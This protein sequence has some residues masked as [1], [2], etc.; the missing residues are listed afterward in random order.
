VDGGPHVSE[1]E[2]PRDPGALSDAGAPSDPG[3]PRDPGALR[4]LEA[5]S[6]PGAQADGERVARA[7]LT[8][9]AEPG[10]PWLAAVVRRHG[11]P[12]TVAA[13]REGRYPAGGRVT[14]GAARAMERWR[15]RLAEIPQ[16]ADLTRLASLGYRLVCPADPLWPAGLKD[17]ADGEPYGLWVRGAVTDLATVTRRSVA[18]VGSRAATAYGSYVAAEI[19]AS[20][21]AR[22]WTVIS[23]GAYGI[24]GCAHRGTI[25]AGGVTM[26]ILACGVDRPY[27]AGHKDLL[28]AVA[29]SGAVISE[30]PPGRSTARLRFLVRN[31]VIAA[32][33]S[34]TLV[35]EAGRRS[36]ALNTARHAG[37]LSRPLM[38]VPGPVTSDL[39]A[40]CHSIIRDWG[41][42]LVTDAD[43]VIERLSAAS[44]GPPQATAQGR[45]PVP[46]AVP[47]AT[48][49]RNRRGRADLAR[50]AL[51]LEAAMVLDA[52]PARGAG[53]ST[54]DIAVRAGLE[55]SVVLAKLAM[56]RV[57]DLAE[58]TDEGW[59]V[60]HG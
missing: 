25:S 11:A 18:I 12:R 59:R 27:P 37:D 46:D 50:D 13:I 52:L 4:D 3:A 45:G 38:A 14:A 40:G 41:G 19:A 2:A 24:D 26:A 57:Y 21:A 48:S 58:R 5:L 53:M 22:G 6:D 7:A 33:A 20:V 39:S 31:R 23:G 49:P 55:P 15:L 30:W 35:V 34:G 42:T 8:Y 29:A 32:M 51:D 47:S 44:P 10:D 36:G 17:L 1:R 28:D 43:E 9:L 54:S 56:L 60:S 16:A